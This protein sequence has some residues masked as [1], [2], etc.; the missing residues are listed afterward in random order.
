MSIDWT[1]IDSAIDALIYL[2]IA[3]L[4]AK[5]KTEE[6]AKALAKQKVASLRAETP[7][8]FTP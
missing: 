8:T 3:V 1:K 6:E 7:I 5:G 4:M 2:I